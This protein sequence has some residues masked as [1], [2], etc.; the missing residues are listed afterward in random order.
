MITDILLI[1][2]NGAD[3]DLTLRALRQC[4][5]ELKVMHIEDGAE[6]LEFMFSVSRNDEAAFAFPR[7]ILMDLLLPKVNGQ[8]ILRA[9][10]ANDATKMIP[11]V[12]LTSSG[13]QRDVTE[14]YMLGANAYMVKPLDFN[15]HIRQMS[16]V[17]DFW[18][19][20]NQYPLG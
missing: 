5:P 9:V 2:D 7:L 10:K 8:E 17:I 4:R 15:E 20:V 19:D 16:K 13:H 11:V 3:A 6:A 1:E 14:C 18:F 12:V